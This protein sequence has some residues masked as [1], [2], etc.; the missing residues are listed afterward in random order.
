MKNEEWITAEETK[1]NSP[2]HSSQIH[3]FA[4]VPKQAKN[5]LENYALSTYA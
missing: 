2:I 3:S 5:K 1:T 4:L